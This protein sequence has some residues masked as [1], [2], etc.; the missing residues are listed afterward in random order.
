MVIDTRLAG[1]PLRA[2]PMDRPEDVQP[3]PTN[4]KVYILLTNN[5]RRRPEQAD[6]A[7]PRPENVF[8]HIIEM[9]APDGDHTAATFRW[10]ILIK[11]G[12]PRVAAV[13]AQW[14]PEQSA[15]GWFGSPDNCAFD[16]EGRLWITTDQ[17]TA[18]PRTQQADGI[19]AVETEGELRGLSKLF[20][21][22]PVGAEMCGPCFTPDGS[23]LFLAVQHPATDG[24]KDWK[25]FG[26]NRPS[27]TRRR[28]GR[29][30]SPACRRAPP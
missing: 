1:D 25:P 18:W 2:T 14:H 27:R 11:C 4:G 5:A 6:K 29:I 24:V 21:R 15:D 30:S 10:D 9:T 23:T 22:A 20:F 16:A 28:G 13:G 3:H 17:G 26:G 8:G 12:D 7:N 19:Y